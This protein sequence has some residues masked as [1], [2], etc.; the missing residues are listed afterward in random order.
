MRLPLRYRSGTQSLKP[1]LQKFRLNSTG[2]RAKGALC[3]S[4][5][6]LQTTWPYVT[7][8]FLKSWGNSTQMTSPSISAPPNVW[9]RKSKPPGSTKRSCKSSCNTTK[10]TSFI[11]PPVQIN[12]TWS[13][14]KTV[15]WTTTW[16]I[17]IQLSSMTR[18]C[19]RRSCSTKCSWKKTKTER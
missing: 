15:S 9:S 14:P 2:S 13:S 16:L 17:L 5:A 4:K 8:N 11:T 1:K 10:T 7:T 3:I 12:P 19:P 18:W 6:R